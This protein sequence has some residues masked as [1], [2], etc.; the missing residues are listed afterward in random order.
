MYSSTT[1]REVTVVD[2]VQLIIAS[3]PAR[4]HWNDDGSAHM[5][6]PSASY[7]ACT[8]IFETVVTRRGFPYIRA[9]LQQVRSR[10]SVMHFDQFPHVAGRCTFG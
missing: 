4:D 1:L 9:G 2:G 8:F 5:W 3:P 6:R 7:P 10:G